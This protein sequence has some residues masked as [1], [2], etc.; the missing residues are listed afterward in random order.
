L[1]AERDDLI[2]I[3]HA[4][5][6]DQRLRVVD[7]LAQ[8]GAYAGV[9]D[10]GIAPGDVFPVAG[11]HVFATQFDATWEGDPVEVYGHVGW[12]QDSDTNGNLAGSPRQSWLYYAGEGLYRLTPRLYAAARYSGASAQRLVSAASSSRDVNS[13]GLVHRLQLGGGYW[14]TKTVLTKLEYVYQLYNGFQASGSQVS[15][16]DAWL[17]PNFRGVIAEASFSF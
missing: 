13:G 6:I 9:L 3:Q 8:D 10:N 14:L 11:Q 16:V 7:A 4:T 17:D 2:V 5:G 12:V 15:G 1:I